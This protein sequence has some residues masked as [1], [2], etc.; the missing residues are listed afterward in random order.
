MPAFRR[1]PMDAHSFARAQVSTGAVDWSG[2]PAEGACVEDLDPV[3]L[4]RARNVLRRF[5]PQ[6]ELLKIDNATFLNALGAVRNGRVT[7]TGL[8]LFGREEL[9]SALCPQHQ[10]HYVYQV[11]E[12]QVSRND[13]FRAGVLQI[14]ER[15]EQAFTGPANPEQ[16]VS[17]GLFKLRIP[18]YHVEV[19]REAVLNAVTHRDYSDPGEVLIRHTAQELVL[20]S[21][22]GFI[23]GIT[24]Q[25]ILRH[26]PAARN[27]TLAEAI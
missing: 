23:A 2:G 3:E 21:P 6:S 10:V 24:P 19:V 27:R 4:A 16:E 9:I 20:T 26:E 12:T 5:K 14:L 17:V 7:R 15:I 18:A 11:S 1:M 13:S 8:L 22:G 25:N